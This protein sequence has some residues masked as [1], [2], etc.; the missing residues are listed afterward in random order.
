M[1]F[2]ILLS[3]AAAALGAISLSFA[4]VAVRVSASLRVELPLVR[5]I[6]AK[7]AAS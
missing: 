2:A 4:A 6:V 1:R 7:L 5:L 3:A